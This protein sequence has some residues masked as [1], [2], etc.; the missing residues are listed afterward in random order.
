MR[1]FLRHSVEPTPHVLL[2]LLDHPLFPHYKSPTALL[3]MHHLTCVISSLLHSVNLI[4]FTVL[5][6]YLILQWGTG[7]VLVSG[8]VC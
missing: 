3:H 4:L 5:L 8:Y 6:V 1:F 7:F 2:P